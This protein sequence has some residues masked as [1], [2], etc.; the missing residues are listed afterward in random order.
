MAHIEGIV[1]EGIVIE[2]IVIVNWPIQTTI[3]IELIPILLIESATQ[4]KR[5][6]NTAPINSTTRP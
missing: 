2:G 4:C 1:I 5:K 3:S 6:R